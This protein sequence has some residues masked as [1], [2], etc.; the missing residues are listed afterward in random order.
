MPMMRCD[1][2]P[3]AKSAAFTGPD[4]TCCHVPRSCSTTG[5]TATRGSTRGPSK[6]GD[7]NVSRWRV[8][9]SS[10]GND[11]PAN[12]RWP[13]RS[14][15]AIASSGSGDVLWLEADSSLAVASLAVDSDASSA[16]ASGSVVPVVEDSLG[17]PATPW[18]PPPPP[19]PSPWPAPPP[20]PCVPGA[21]TGLGIGSGV[22]NSGRLFQAGLL[23]VLEPPPSPYAPASGLATPLAVPADG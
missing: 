2:P 22:P 12:V 8:G 9:V 5:S 1:A 14:P 19:V 6:I 3:G 4:S 15:S 18:P 20:T 17:S 13:G 16:T 7:G 21:S 11:S 23:P 10:L